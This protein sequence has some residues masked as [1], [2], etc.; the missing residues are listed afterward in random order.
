[1]PFRRSALLDRLAQ[2]LDPKVTCWFS[3]RLVDYTQPRSSG[4]AISLR[5]QDETIA[6]CDVLIGADGIHSYTRHKLLKDVAQRAESEEEA[7][8]LLA[9]V[10]PVWSGTVAYRAV[11][12][13][14]KLRVVNPN[15][16]VLTKPI[17]V[18][19]ARVIVILY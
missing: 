13:C 14:A 9:Q 6:T 10:D 17:L 2:C 15:H 1:M 19:I 12:P 16:R 5:F 18:S 4:G 11:I 7:T 8:K 3:K